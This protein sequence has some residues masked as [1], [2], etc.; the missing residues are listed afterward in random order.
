MCICCCG[1]S[2]LIV[3]CNAALNGG[4]L[5]LSSLH[6]VGRTRLETTRT[7]LVVSAESETT[8]FLEVKIPGRRG[9]DRRITWREAEA[10]DDVRDLVLREGEWI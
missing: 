2:A 4:Y 3:V 10:I 7:V 9:P 5:N 8:N 1:A 6:V